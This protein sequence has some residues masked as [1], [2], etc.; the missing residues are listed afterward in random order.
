VNLRHEPS[1]SQSGVQRL[2]H[3]ESGLRRA[4]MALNVNAFVSG[5]P[6]FAEQVALFA[7]VVGPRGWYRANVS[8]FSE[9]C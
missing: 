8:A 4:T 6:F 9:P 7:D 5:D 3:L 2:L 1:L